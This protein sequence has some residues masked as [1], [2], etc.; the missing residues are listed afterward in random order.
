M[1]GIS[2]RHPD[3]YGCGRFCA[4]YG[5]WRRTVSATMRQIH[6]AGEKLFVDFAGDTVPVFDVPSGEVRAAHIFVAVLGASNYTF[7]QARWSEGLADWTGVHVDGFA[8]F[9]GVPALV[10][11][12]NLKAG[13]T[14]AWS[15]GLPR[16]SLRPLSPPA[17]AAR[18]TRTRSRRWPLRASADPPG[19][20]PVAYPRRL[21]A[22]AHDRR[23]APRS[24]RNVDDRHGRASTIVTS[25]VPVEH[26]HD[27][28]GDPTLADAILDRL[29]HNAHRLVLKGESMRKLNAQ[30]DRL[31]APPYPEPITPPMTPPR[32]ASSGTPG[33]F[34]WNRWPTSIEIGGR[35]QRNAQSASSMCPA[36]TFSGGSA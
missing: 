10:V 32:P 29:V 13:I 9:G 35:L 7:A 30:R 14:A 28:I 19:P 36:D 23:A 16:R 21:G 24:S 2:G 12:D 31:E 6:V 26:W 25:Q 22:R 15:Q 11:C 5:A 34:D 8:F 27:V 20:G 3:G 1:G 18:G 33:G 4:H 17:P